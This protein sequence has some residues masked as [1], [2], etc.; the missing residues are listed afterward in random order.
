MRKNK[1]RPRFSDLGNKQL[2]FFPFYCRRRRNRRGFGEREIHHQDDI[3]AAHEPILPGQAPAPEEGRHGDKQQA[4]EPAPRD[5]NP[6]APE[7]A[8]DHER[9]AHEEKTGRQG[10]EEEQDDDDSG[11]VP[12]Q[13][14][15][16]VLA[17]QRQRARAVGE[18]EHAQQHGAAETDRPAQRLRGPE[19]AGAG[20]ELQGEGRQGGH[21]AGGRAVLRPAGGGFRRHGEAEGRAEAPAGEVEGEGVA[22]A[23]ESG[24]EAVDR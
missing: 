5:K 19:D 1:Q 10:R 23:E 18:E 15:S 8:A 11:D 20:G 22:A 9:L 14:K 7:E 13:E 2:Q 24:G 4:A 6:D 16:G 3:R 21:P 12:V 17:Q